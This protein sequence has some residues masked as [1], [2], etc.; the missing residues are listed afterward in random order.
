MV[1]LRSGVHGWQMTVAVRHLRLKRGQCG[2]VVGRR[3]LLLLLLLLLLG[4]VWSALWRLWLLALLT[5]GRLRILIV[6][7][8][9]N[10]SFDLQS[11]CSE[12]RIDELVV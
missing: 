4:T 9:P 10:S 11:R 12:T 7:H 1:M 2:L 6:I 5:I 8:S 3:L